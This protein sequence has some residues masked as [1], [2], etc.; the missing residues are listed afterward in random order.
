[1]HI[2]KEEGWIYEGGEGW[3]KQ[4]AMEILVAIGD[5]K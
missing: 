1:M 4:K 2:T 5:I 3:T